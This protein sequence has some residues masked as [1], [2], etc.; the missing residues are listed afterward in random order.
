M[1]FKK[2]KILNSNFKKS[3]AFFCVLF[4]IFCFF[5]A[6]DSDEQC[7]QNAPVLMNVRF[8][9]S[10]IDTA[11]MQKN[12]AATFRIGA[13]GEGTDSVLYQNAPVSGINLPLNKL[14]NHSA[15]TLSVRETD[16]T[17]TYTETLTVWHSNIEEY[18]FECGCLV[19]F[20]IDSV[21]ITNQFIDSLSVINKNIN[22]QNAENIQLYR[23]Y[24]YS[25]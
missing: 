11:G 24:D 13:K 3:Y 16:T 23:H 10:V 6:C 9:K 7:R 12:S 22:T 21:Q 8:Y 2:I 5:A 17:A 19:T 14:D 25:R 18:S 4:F 20:K 15:F 1:K